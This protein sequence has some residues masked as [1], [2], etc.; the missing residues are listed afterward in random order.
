MPLEGLPFARTVRGASGRFVAPGRF[1]G[2]T[3]HGRDGSEIQQPGCGRLKHLVIQ[4]F[5]LGLVELRNKALV[6]GCDIPPQTGAQ[7]AAAPRR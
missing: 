4:V 5:P 7:K 1:G 3:V 6:V 2:G